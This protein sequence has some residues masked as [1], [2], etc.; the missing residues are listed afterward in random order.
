VFTDIEGSTRLWEQDR[1]AM[2]TVVE[3]QIALLR[4]IAAAHGGTLY[5]VVGDG[6]QSAFPTAEQALAAA[7]DGQRALL[8]E[9]WPDPPGPLRV[10]AAIHA[11][12]ATPRDGDYLAA[13]LNRLARLLGVGHGGQI[14]ATHA[15]QQLV[16]DDLPADVVLRDLGAHRLRDLHEPEEVFQVVAAGLPATFPSLRSLAGHPTNLTAP[17]TSIIGRETEIA[18][19]VD[20]FEDGA[21]LVTLTGPGGTGKT[22]LAQEIAAEAL[23][24]FPDGVFFVDLSPLRDAADVMSTVASVLGIRETAGESPRDALARYLADRR[25]LLVLDNCEQ[26]L[27][28][29]TDIDALLA[30]CPRLAVLA[31]S[32]E[33]L[34]LRAEQVFRVPPLPVPEGG[35]LPDLAL[36]AVIPS[37]ALFVERARAGEPT[38]D[39]TEENARTVAAICRRLDGL[40]L[41]IELAAARVRHFPPPVLLTRLERALPV[42]TGGP[43]DAPERQRTLRQAIAWSYD[44]LTGDEQDVLRALA[45]F[46]GGCTFAAAEAVS[47]VVGDADVFDGLGSLIDKNLLLLDASGSEP[48]YR[49]LE[50]IREFALDQLAASPDEEGVRR[51]HLAYLER[52]SRETDLFDL[53]AG[54]TPAFEAPVARLAEEEANFR[55]ALEWALIH[56]AATAL[57]VAAQLGPYWHAQNRPATG[58][59]LL[60]RALA[61]GAGEDTPER[62]LALGE[63][64]YLAMR[65]AE[66]ARA[67][68]LADAAFALAERLPEPLLAALARYCHGRI[69]FGRGQGERAVA[70]LQ[71]A[72]TRFEILGN[73][74]LA[75]GCLND[76]GRNA[77]DQGEE[78]SAIAFFERCLAFDEE[79]Q[80]PYGRA[81]TLVNLAYSYYYLG[82]HEHH[83]RAQD[84]ATEALALAERVGGAYMQGAASAMPQALL[85]ELAL[86]R[87]ELPRAAV[88][89]RACLVIWWEMGDRLSV[90]EE[91]ENVARLSIAAEYAET[92]ASLYGAADAFR[93]AISSPRTD[94]NHADYERDLLALREA[95]GESGFASAWER[96][97]RR[98]LADAVAEALTVL[99]AIAEGQSAASATNRSGA[100]MP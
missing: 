62:A 94:V 20:R 77:L 60:E 17:A 84:L 3:R 85:G 30:T 50:T 36:L 52:L 24:H 70:Q 23:A 29:A 9:A 28:A 32:R 33:P 75:V 10:R 98:P 19:V 96:V 88:C 89:F 78:S 58:L 63:A 2:H 31:T 38:F 1:A 13:P 27:P 21:R 66:F 86:D 14:L 90:A 40:P 6:T 49:M 39:L 72:L 42:L 45:V 64:A 82:Q 59:D 74:A 8:A 73:A 18:A 48:R 67:E 91:L 11:G 41:A 16:R 61:T 95:L 5:K 83:E 26:L 34:R 22:R 54:L 12:Q 25:Q 68:A 65:L 76:L 93:E 87:R 79:R 53:F 51:A 7:V 55:A 97:R 100:A 43:R 4:K 35:R 37:V 44:L 56:D 46:V 69:A 15:V 81:V 80:N 71:D 47:A 92:A 57:A 99:D